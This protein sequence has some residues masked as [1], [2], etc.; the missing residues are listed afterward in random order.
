[1]TLLRDAWLSRASS[2][3][4][5]I[6][7]R[8]GCSR[9]REN[10]YFCSS[11]VSRSTSKYWEFRDVSTW[12]VVE[13]HVWRYRRHRWSRS[14][15]N[16]LKFDRFVWRGREPYQGVPTSTEKIQ[17]LWRT[18]MYHRLRL[19]VCRLSLISLNR[20]LAHRPNERNVDSE[21][22]E[23]RWKASLSRR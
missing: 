12:S 17:Q 11:N 7:P 1:M 5:T 4:L 8:R 10:A 13:R 15:G 16:L 6:A 20:N 2:E 19:T 22:S 3:I 23:R 18:G 9:R 14:V 21:T